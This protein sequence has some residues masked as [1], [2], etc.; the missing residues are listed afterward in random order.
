M[1]RSGL[2]NQLNSMPDPQSQPLS[3]FTSFCRQVNSAA[4]NSDIIRR[5]TGA[6]FQ[7]PNQD[8]VVNFSQ[9]SQSSLAHSAVPP[10]LASEPPGEL[11]PPFSDVDWRGMGLRYSHPQPIINPNMSVDTLRINYG[12]N[13]QAIICPDGAFQGN[14]EAVNYLHAGCGFI[15]HIFVTRETWVSARHL[16]KAVGNNSAPVSEAEGTVSSL[17]F[18]L[19]KGITRALVVHDN[20]DMHSFI[21]NKSTSKKK[22]SRYARLKERIV[23]L[24]ARMDVVYGCHV[25]SH[26]GSQGLAENEA[27]D[28]LASLFMKYSQLGEL[29]PTKLDHQFPTARTIMN[30][31]LAQ[32]PGFSLF[33]ASTIPIQPMPVLP[34]PCQCESCGCPSHHKST[35]FLL[36]HKPSMSSFTR[37]KPARKPAFCESF[38]CPEDIDWNEAPNV[39]D[40]HTFVQFLGTMFSLCTKPAS[41]TAAWM[42]IVQ[43]AHF[44]F[45]SPFRNKLVKKKPE[46]T[47]ES[48]GPCVD[49]QFAAFEVEAS[50]MHTFARIAHDRKWGRAMRFVHKS[51]RISPLD[52]RLEGQWSA[53]HPEP[54]G[55]NDEL[56]IDYV[57]AS[58]EVFQ[59]DRREL[60][61]KIDSWDVTK[62]AGLS[63]FPPS[64]LIHFNNLTA[65]YEDPEHPNP[66]FTSFVL[67]MECLASG[68]LVQL[69]EFA[70]NY[71]GSFLNKVPSNVGFK[72]RN[73]GMSDT[74]H[75][76]ASYTILTRSIPLATNAGL[77]DEFD[78]G[79]GKLGGIE[80]FVKI[81]QAI[82]VDK[83]ITVLSSDIE[84]AYN[85]VLRTD[86]WLAIQDIDFPPLTQWFIYSYG[87]S[88]SV[89][90]I[91]D[92]RLPGSGANVKKVTMRIGFPQG[93]SLS[94]FLFSITLRYVLRPFFSSLRQAQ[95][96]FGFA[97][98]L[99]DTL[100][101][102]S[103]AGLRTMGTN[104]Q[105]FINT[106]AARNLKINVS[107]SLVYCQESSLGLVTQIRK[108]KGLRLSHEGFDVCKIPVG[109]PNFINHY[110][111][112]TYLP[113]IDEAFDSMEHIWKSLQYLKNQERYNTYYIF[114]RLCF[115]SK[116]QYWIRNLQPV[117]AHPLSEIIDAKITF[118]ADRLYPQLPSNI[119]IRQ[120][121]FVEMI[122]CSRKI[123]A[124]PLV[125]NGAGITRMAPIV[126]IGHYATCAESFGLLVRFAKTVSVDI[127]AHLSQVDGLHNADAVREQLLPGYG[128]TVQQLLRD[129]GDVLK[130]NDFA[131]SPD[132]EY[133]G[134]QHRASHA[135]FITN[136]RVISEAL[137]SSE[138]KAWFVS[139]KDSFSSLALNSSIRHVTRQRPPL[140]KVFPSVMAM[141][142]MRPIFH[143]HQC[144][145]GSIVDVC[146]LHFLR[147]S[148]ANPSPFISIHNKVRDACT[149]VLQDYVRRNSP[150]Q[151]K[152]FSEVEKFHMCEIKKYYPTA[153]GADNHRADAVVFEECDPWHPWFID[154]VQAQIDD[155]DERNTMRHVNNAYQRKITE[156]VRDHISIP[157]TSII[158]F[159]FCSNGVFHPQSLM[160]LDWFLCR[161][162]HAPIDQPPAVEK[163]RVLQAIS[164]AVV[165]Q[166]ATILSSHFNRF[167]YLLYERSFPLLLPEEQ[168]RFLP[169]RGRRQTSFRGGSCRLSSA[170]VLV[171]QTHALSTG[172]LPA[173]NLSAPGPLPSS[174]A[175]ARS[176][177]RLRLRRERDVAGGL[178][179]HDSS[180]AVAVGGW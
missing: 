124:L 22:C 34:A 139:R 39:M 168:G 148:L 38:L 21:C 142:T 91:I 19:S 40:D 97:T 145:C 14:R 69:R 28:Q 5:S 72:V 120:D 66:Y 75:R 13:F 157:R 144:G 177:E 11:R 111:V 60:S 102:L 152:I 45:F 76:L 51:E 65:K 24:L 88:P 132:Q 93:D 37:E 17:E 46:I 125:L 1:P 150:S 149:R 92:L 55:E 30:Q 73:L 179:G 172:N 110:V 165:D 160:F 166:T 31:I 136:H 9:T 49:E 74:F 154:F 29:P 159:A 32:F 6:V 163:L 8:H 113:R 48:D 117:S 57:P 104:I 121:Q 81:A 105:E 128:A 127:S 18:L 176:S 41:V 129:C 80:K 101:A 156:L 25:R 106:L 133:Q 94:G 167:V 122:D 82:A 10:R 131:L 20:Y 173:F 12:A 44:Y 61:R 119:S 146:G 50:R 70:L 2:H 85:N 4:D 98:V 180:A 64:F 115:A 62:A 56:E 16:P 141:R 134:V 161:A 174:L 42:C 79:S 7:N 52:P 26:A 116:F 147:C 86:T 96:R 77:L 143:Q 103:S 84:K 169:R 178:A 15:C 162:S 27:A 83:N 153:Q 175:A 112:N 170:E 3:P 158:P 71:K 108:I 123:E 36:R 109:S 95:V 135:F 90:Y 118:L 67:F 171:P 54:P 58:Y 138:Y 47:R 137:P 151:L 89:N 78:L 155:P 130:P 33:T 126:C 140:D 107:K 164:S 43:L 35:C 99:D 59:L 63:G 53:I 68:K 87:N 100:F 23:S 114:L